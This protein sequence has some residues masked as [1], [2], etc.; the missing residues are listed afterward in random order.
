MPKASGVALSD[1]KFAWVDFYCERW[2]WKVA[3]QELPSASTDKK[4]M[5]P[6]SPICVLCLED[7][8]NLEPKRYCAKKIHQHRLSIPFLRP[9]V[10]SHVSRIRQVCFFF[11]VCKKK[12]KKSGHTT[13][14]AYEHQLDAALLEEEN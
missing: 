5:V 12:K 14:H 6:G 8:H 10:N 13:A 3:G 9:L 2:G 11:V 4:Q 7:G 1:R